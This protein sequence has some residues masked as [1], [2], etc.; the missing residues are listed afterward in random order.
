MGILD[1][2]A[3]LLG[4]IIDFSVPDDFE[5]LLLTCHALFACGSSSIPTHNARRKHFR[6]IS[7]N[8]YHDE[9]SRLSFLRNIAAEPVAAHYV[10]SADLRGRI[11]V[12]PSLHEVPPGF[13]LRKGCVGASMDDVEK[14]VAASQFSHLLD[15]G[16]ETWTCQAEDG[17]SASTFLLTL[18]TNVRQLTLPRGWPEVPDV[19]TQPWQLLNAM[20]RQSHERRMTSPL[21]QLRSLR[22]LAPVHYDSRVGLSSLS[23]FLAMHDLEEL[24]AT[25][26]VAIDDYT[27]IP[28][29]WI[30]PDL[31]SPLR[32]IEFVSCCMDSSQL[33]NLLANTPNLQ[34]FRYSHQEKWHTC[35]HDWNA[36]AFAAAIG[37]YCGHQL[38]DL[39][40][41]V[42]GL[43]GEI[44]TGIVSLQE[45][46]C[47]ERAELDVA[48]FAGPSPESGE[49]A[50]L[51]A[52]GPS[53]GFQKWSPA[54][55]PKLTEILP[56]ST[57][58]FQLFDSSLN[59]Y[60][61]VACSLLKDF[62]AGRDW[63]LSDLEE[64]V[65]RKRILDN[66]EN[67]TGA[68]IRA[69]VMDQAR[70]VGVEYRSGLALQPIWRRAFGEKC[71]VVLDLN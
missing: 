13:R 71:G 41:T 5:N 21:C 65:L 14:L 10:Q 37:R 70:K 69:R 42:D 2:P 57:K 40:L 1:L 33:S 51:E 25:S 19:N 45:F 36:G 43:S 48:L 12:T 64:V 47:L 52:C 27:G 58:N 11:M 24:Y 55:V 50:G 3:E 29:T 30:Y 34:S 32:K 26:C 54:M 44:V 22:A 56:S 7:F 4:R 9:D 68:K 53:K 20:M 35:G 67:P 16:A 60:S 23:A 49:M 38:T 31:K 28:F 46:T 61:E 66:P 39:A 59:D 17:F 62:S 18:L 15:T 63:L 6:H 8:S